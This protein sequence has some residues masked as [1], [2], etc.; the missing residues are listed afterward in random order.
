MAEI[1]R[2]PPQE[3]RS[4]VQAG[5]SLFIC[6]YDSEEMCGRMLLEGAITLGE[7]NSRLA[8]MSRDQDL[9]FYCK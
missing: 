8:G 1:R 6:A 9:I 4:R 5:R 2:I 3:V 7:L